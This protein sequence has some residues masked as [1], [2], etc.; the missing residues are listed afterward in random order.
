MTIVGYWDDKN[1][2]RDDFGDWDDQGDWNDQSDWNDQG[3]WNDWVT[4]MTRMT[5]NRLGWL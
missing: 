5:R 1:D 3:D 4:G 2:C